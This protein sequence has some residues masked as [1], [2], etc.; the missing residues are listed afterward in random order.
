M[1]SALLRGFPT[2]PIKFARGTMMVSFALSQEEISLPTCLNGRGDFVSA[3]P[4]E[5]GMSWDG[6]AC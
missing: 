4:Y 3:G 1:A 6:A 2:D 5:T